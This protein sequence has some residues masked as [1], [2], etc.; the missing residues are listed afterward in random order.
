M[1]R[2][3]PAGPWISGFVAGI[4]DICQVNVGSSLCFFGGR[5]RRRRWWRWWWTSCTTRT[6]AHSCLP[7]SLPAQL[8][9]HAA[10]PMAVALADHPSCPFN[11][12]S[13]A[14]PLAFRQARSASN[15]D[16]LLITRF[17]S[18]FI[19]RFS[20]KSRPRASDIL[21]VSARREHVARGPENRSTL[22]RHSSLQLLQ[23]GARLQ[24]VTTKQTNINGGSLRP[25]HPASLVPFP[26]LVSLSLRIPKIPQL[27]PHRPNFHHLSKI[28]EER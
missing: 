5:W 22:H 20:H 8:G 6:V 4:T 16:P 12:L 2:S 17:D 14:L 3:P 10:S 23:E 18:A 26:F 1:R 21:V 19:V 24:R 11:L 28:E 15:L 7:Q 25:H 9:E 27:Y 13:L